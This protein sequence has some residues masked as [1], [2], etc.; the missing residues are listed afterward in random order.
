MP[1]TRN[2]PAPR[3]QYTD[4]SGISAKGKRPR[5]RQQQAT[6]AHTAEAVTLPGTV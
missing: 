4:G 1:T 6:Q 5:T 2:V 3:A